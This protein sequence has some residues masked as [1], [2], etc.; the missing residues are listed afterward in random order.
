[1]NWAPRH[2]HNLSAQ[3]GTEK[4][5]YYMGLG[6]SNQQSVISSKDF[7]YQRYNLI[8]NIDAQISKRLSASLDFG[9]SYEHASETE[10]S[11]TVGWVYKALGWQ[12]TQIEG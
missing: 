11:Q 7:W 8:A 5:S 4:V 9:Y 10:L 1:M 12:P 6:Y 2:K 3:G